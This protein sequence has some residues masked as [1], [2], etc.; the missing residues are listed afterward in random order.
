MLCKVVLALA[1]SLAW[2]G[3]AHAQDTEPSSELPLRQPTGVKNES[4]SGDQASHNGGDTSPDGRAAPEPALESPASPSQSSTTKVHIE[5]GPRVQLERV[6]SDGTWV[7]V[8]MAPCD[9]EVSTKE[10]YRIN[11]NGKV[12]SDAFRLPKDG[13]PGTTL[14]VNTAS[15]ALR[16]I[17]STA[18][19]VGALPVA[20]AAVLFVGGAIVIG[21]VVILA[22]PF[23]EVLGGSFG[24]CAETLFGGA[25]SAYWDWISKTPVWGTIVGGVALGSTGLVLLGTN[26]RTRVS[27]GGTDLAFLNEQTPG[28]RSLPRVVA[29]PV[30][31]A[32]F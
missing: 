19:I 9:Q 22:C 6:K 10:T 28:Q 21:V 32:A 27:Q 26:R 24:G 2:V 31:S 11:A 30:L 23:A 5:S 14:E 13:S 1:F 17:G 3:V 16:T 7:K 29:L 25:G 15:S 12:A 8:C 18:L 20:G 4:A